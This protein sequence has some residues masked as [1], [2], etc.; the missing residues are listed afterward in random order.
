MRRLG[1]RDVAVRNR[2]Q[3]GGY[4]PSKIL[5]RAQRRQVDPETLRRVD[6]SERRRQ[7]LRGKGPQQ[8][9]LALEQ[10]QQ[11]LRAQRPG[12]KIG[13]APLGIADAARLAARVSR[14]SLGEMPAR[15][16]R[17]RPKEIRTK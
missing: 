16:A 14:A 6:G 7:E 3:H 5:E 4:H 2:R 9:G 10:M 13:H 11:S 12:D 17:A 1:G 8:I 15:I